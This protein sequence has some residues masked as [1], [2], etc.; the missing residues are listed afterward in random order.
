M[1]SVRHDAI[2]I[3]AE[4][5]ESGR[6]KTKVCHEVIEKEARR[7]KNPHV[8]SSSCAGSGSH[9]VAVQHKK[10]DKHLRSG[11]LIRYNYAED[12]CFRE[13]DV[14]SRCQDY[15]FQKFFFLNAFNFRKCGDFVT[16]CKTGEE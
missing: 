11:K 16:W 7:V 4:V 8:G 15:H 2:V 9:V 13:S 5:T 3:Q 12:E 6:V 10:L 14:V 1:P